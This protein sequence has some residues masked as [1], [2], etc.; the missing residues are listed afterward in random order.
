MG[1][2]SSTNQ[3]QERH[4][5]AAGVQHGGGG[6][7][8]AGA[9]GAGAGGGGGFQLR[10]LAPWVYEGG[11]LSQFQ[12]Q[13]MREEF[14]E[15][16]KNSGGSTQTWDALKVA[17]EAM[18]NGNHEL[19]ETVLQT[20]S[21]T[22]ANGT[23]SVCFDRRRQKYSIPRYCWCTPTNLREV[24]ADGALAGGKTEE[25]AEAL[26]LPVSVRISF[27]EVLIKLEMTTTSTVGEVK[28]AVHEWLVPKVKDVDNPMTD[29]LPPERQRMFYGG[30]ELR[31]SYRLAACGLKKNHVLQVTGR[32]TPEQ[33]AEFAA[34]YS[35]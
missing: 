24:G 25:P 11:A 21:I 2:N 33:A 7:G 34:R 1:C 28:Q 16:V 12:L 15:K 5:G 23:L 10:T 3:Q 4:V 30:R 31:D 14:W 17:C 9:G 29:D 22:T 27:T 19:A 18:C 35:L 8:G 6:A 13:C 20:A 32:P 26:P